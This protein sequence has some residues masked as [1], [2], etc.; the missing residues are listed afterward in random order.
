M[1]EGK[2]G[3]IFVDADVVVLA[4]SFE[5][6]KRHKPSESLIKSFRGRLS[7]TFW[8]YLEVLGVLSYNLPA[9]KVD[10]FA[11]R[12]KEMITV[13]GRW[14]AEELVFKN[15][16]KRMKAAD[17]LTLAVLENEMC[18]TFITWNVQDFA[19]RTPIAVVTPDKI[20]SRRS[21]N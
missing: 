1:D 10:Y 5:R 21:L 17:A 18:D 4:F 13:G 7:M 6:D 3:R 19:G 9:Q 12:L 2:L 11:T 8:N 16:I 15:I 20:L 14:P